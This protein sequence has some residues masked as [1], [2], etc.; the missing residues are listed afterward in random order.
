MS[1]LPAPLRPVDRTGVRFEGRRLA[2][3]AGCDYY[4]L[5]TH[6]AVLA[7]ARDA[8]ERHGLG[9]G[10]SRLTTGN[11]PLY[12][13]L[14]HWLARFFHAPAA[15]LVHS[16]YATNPVVAQALANTVTH[17]FIDA[18]AHPSL[19]DAATLLGCPVTDFAHRDPADLD[20]HLR[21]LPADARPLVLTDGLFSHD[22]SIA[23]LA[24]HLGVLP[25]TGLLLV[26]EAHAA[27]VLGDRG[28]GSAEHC[29]VRDPRL[30]RTGTLSKAFGS[31]G[32]FVLAP[33]RLVDL[34]ITRSR[35]FAGSTPTPLPLVAAALV[36]GRL[37]Q[38]DAA[39]RTRLAA[40]TRRVKTAAREAGLAS[41]DT[42][43]P[44]L[45]VIPSG[46][47]AAQRIRRA[48]LRRRTFPSLIRYPGGP[49]AGY[50]RFALSSEHTEAD[51]AGLAMAFADFNPPVSPAPEI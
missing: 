15:L 23:P 36:A 47:A 16:G 34:V 30:V 5:S 20:R 8:L 41:P 3:F 22:G 31:G 46:P 4:R 32:G 11:H 43:A 51:L 39:M 44:M 26:D 28:G 27:G 13:E 24:E 1:A 7:A 33:R 40:N 38:E 42:P 29:G 35:W 21:E 45:G 17:A 2:Y 48:L 6:P 14:E 50:Y 18:R 49:P 19:R 10:A 9:V 37:I 25:D 12:E